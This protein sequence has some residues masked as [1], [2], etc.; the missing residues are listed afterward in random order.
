MSKS[1]IERLREGEII[2]CKKC[3][4]GLYLPA[5]PEKKIVIVLFAISV[6]HLL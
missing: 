2:K 3:K 4:K 1:L 5:S 6:M